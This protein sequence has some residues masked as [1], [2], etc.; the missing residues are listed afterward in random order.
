MTEN[1]NSRTGGRWEQ[2]V[3]SK[4]RI[5]IGIAVLIALILLAFLTR[6]P[7]LEDRVMSHDETTHVY[8]SW[9]LEQGRGYQHDPLSHGPFQFHLVAA[10]YFLFG[11]SD[12]SARFPAALF[13]VAAVGLVWLYH[14]WIGRIGA[15]VAAGLMLVSPYMLFYSRYVRNEALVVPLA[16]LMVW[17]V[18]R[19]METRKAT[20][21]YVTS[22]TLSLHFATK[23]TSYIL[24]ALVM[25]FLAAYLAIKIIR[26][27]WERKGLKIVFYI[28][29]AALVVAGA[30]IAVNFALESE[31]VTGV[32]D[33]PVEPAIPSEDQSF[34]SELSPLVAMG[35]ILS[36]ISVLIIA[37][38]MLLE[39]G[40]RLRTEFA[41]FDILLVMSTLILPLL[42]ALP[43]NLLGWDP[44]AYQDPSSIQ[45]TIVVILVL[46]AFAAVVGLLWDWK[47]WLIAAA[48]FYLPF[49]VLYTTFFTNGQGL[50]TGLVGSLGYWMVQHGVE[51]GSQPHY[52]YWLLQIPFYEFLPA[53]G[54]ILGA[55]YWLKSPKGILQVEDSQNS[56]GSEHRDAKGLVLTFLVYWSIVSL[57]VYSYAGER[58]PWLTVHITLPLILLA[59]Y[60]IG[61][62]L[63]TVD[64]SR[65]T[66]WKTWLILLLVFLFL[67]STLTALYYI[68]GDRP[69]FRGQQLSELSD[70]MAFIVAFFVSIATS[71][72]VYVLAKEWPIKAIAQ[73]AGVTFIGILVFITARAAFRAAYV[74]YDNAKEFL[75]YAHMGPGPK[76]A[77]N[78]IEDLSYRT[79]DTLDIQVAYDNE[80]TYP[81]WWYLRNFP[82]ALYFGQS[83]SRDLLN[84]PVVVAGDANWG[85]LDPLM[86][87]N[88]YSYDYIRIWWPMQ[89]Y[90]NLSPE[91]IWSAIK[92]PELRSA[93]WQIWFEREYEKYAEV[94]GKDLSLR[95]WQ[96][97]NR[98]RLYIRK[99]IAAQ[100]WDYG[101]TPTAFEIQEF[102]D[103]YLDNLV[104]LDAEVVLG[105]LGT[106]PGQF[107]TPRGI[108]VGPDGSIYVADAQNHRIQRLDPEGEVISIWGE[109]GGAEGEDAPGGTFNEPWGIAVGPDGTVYV[110]DTWNHRVQHFT[111]EGE[112]L[113]AF[114]Y[115]GQAETYDAFWG[116]RDVS[117]DGSG[118]IFVSDTGN[119][120]IV[121]FD[122][123]GNPLGDFGGFGLTLGNLDEPVG[124]DTD[125]QGR[126]Y[127]ADTWNQRVQVFEEITP[128]S[129]EG[130][131]EWSID[132]WYGQS[133]ENKPYISL[134]GEGHVCVSD[135]EA[136]RILCFDTEGNF[137]KGWGSF[138][139]TDS[140]FGLAMGVAFDDA[141]KLWVSDSVNNR[142]MRFDP[143]LCQP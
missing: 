5:D 72:G 58:M 54:A 143:G 41:S 128:S 46:S 31:P 110:A 91:R 14:K 12:A 66:E 81:Y 140:Q 120:R 24:T 96:P 62:Y 142:I 70:T 112:F 36:L 101:I 4:F 21:L 61:R 131:F 103:P 78:Q 104:Y 115:F 25:I 64:W 132:G 106:D 35:G 44:L 86:G 67:I 113:G 79:T 13:G 139:T 88:Y 11:D 100:I 3:N 20:Y 42:A 34:T 121:V 71:I 134:S 98:F 10:S 87:E 99:D 75:V 63:E 136:Y 19:Y 15:L 51:R 32:G 30:V 69:P 23:E 76:T 82:R 116:P 137:I 108:A 111:A 49:V 68:F 29:L 17:A 129:Y 109:Q 125:E 48:V 117:V 135:P 8:F 114:G 33:Q 95:N 53:L 92:S 83:P 122:P 93:L 97:S 9:L 52:Y 73:L 26:Q 130:V 102:V 57:F 80:T 28:G 105:E 37:V 50:A 16:L 138:G 56:A 59:G 141:C 107:S 2:F 84:Y 118:R 90:F 43:A 89:D 55:I 123:E 45:K 39:F 1:L 85:K 124:L 126:L 119:K 74:N 47:R 77:L 127:V 133:L 6:F 60:G 18:F 65:F 38:T 27:P 7:G 40:R 94:T 22:L